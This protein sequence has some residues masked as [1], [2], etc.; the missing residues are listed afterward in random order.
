MCIRDSTYPLAAWIA[1]PLEHRTSRW[2]RLR[3]IL[4]DG[5]AD[6]LPIEQCETA[7][8]ISAMPKGSNDWSTQALEKVRQRFTK[9]IESILKY[10]YFFD[11]ETLGSW[12]ATAVLLSTSQLP[13]E[14]NQMLLRACSLWV[15]APRQPEQVLESLF[16]LGTPLS[17]HVEECLIKCKS[18]AKVHPNDSVFYLWGTLLHAMESN[19]PLA[20]EY[21]RQI[22]T[23]LPASW[24]RAWAGE[25][26][27]IQL[28]STS[29]RRWLAKHPLPWPAMLTRPPGER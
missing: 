11:D 23:K 10:D 21:L 17:N 20:P 15:D 22:M 8:L 12:M 25:W 27:Q 24:W 14:F 29:G 18:A 19:E 3:T 9:N 26:L 13:D 6:L 16:P 5:W 28:T 1:T 2:I 7:T 4:P